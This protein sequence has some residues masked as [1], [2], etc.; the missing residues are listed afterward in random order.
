MFRSKL[1]ILIALMALTITATGCVKFKT[2]K[3]NLNDAGIYKTDNR[4]DRWAHAVLIPTV[5]GQPK[6]IGGINVNVLAMDPSDN[7]AL[8]WG[9]EENGLFYTYDGARSWRLAAGLEQKTIND[10]AVDPNSK[11]VI[12]ACLANE[13]YKSTDCS[14]TWTRIYFDSDTKTQ[15]RAV[16]VDHYDS[17]NVYIGTSRGDI[18]KSS[19]RGE[20]WQV[21]KRLKGDI[22]RIVFSPHD[23][24]IIFIATAGKGLYRSLNGGGDWE[25]LEENLKEFKGSSNY[26]DLVVSPASSGLIFLATNY[27]L[28]KSGDN[29][30]NWEEIELIVPI[31]RAAINA[32]AVNPRNAKEI[33]YVTN[34]TFYRSLDGGKSWTT[35]K[36]PTSG[37]GWK[38]LI[39]PEDPSII[40]M[41]VKKTKK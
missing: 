14:R 30:D 19:D 3:S 15:I 32:I 41:G 11:C 18:I 7:K 16:A 8:Y 5:S 37:F 24:R 26:R 2:K 10:V 38:L 27:S 31:K 12:Y 40:Y 6:N 20:T 21:I 13:V 25:S 4:G 28:L 33:Y 36:L 17:A 35:K 39:D 1:F 9:S 23:S 29:G 22:K 34:T